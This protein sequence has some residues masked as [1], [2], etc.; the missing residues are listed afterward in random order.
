MKIFNS[1]HVSLDTPTV[2]ALGCFDGVHT[3]H[4]QVINK[5]REIARSQRLPLVVWS[6]AEPPKNFFSPSSVPLLSTQREKRKIMSIFFFF[7]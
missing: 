3:G 7:F 1:I 5:A 6:F 2:V 4:M